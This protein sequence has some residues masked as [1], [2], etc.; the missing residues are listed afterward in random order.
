MIF[1]FIFFLIK[2]SRFFALYFLNYEINTFKIKILI[3]F[4]KSLFVFVFAYFINSLLKTF[5]NRLYRYI[6]LN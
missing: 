3:A 2:A 4:K 5:I 6:N 1:E